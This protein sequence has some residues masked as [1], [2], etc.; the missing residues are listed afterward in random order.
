M[1]LRISEMDDCFVFKVIPSED[2]MNTK[3]VSGDNVNKTDNSNAVS[4]KGKYKKQ[5]E[6]IF[7]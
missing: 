3:Q 7:V 2:I 6:C 5:G 4:T 1:N